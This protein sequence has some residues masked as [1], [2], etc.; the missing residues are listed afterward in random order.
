MPLVHQNEG[1]DKWRC[2]AT[3]S[4]VRQGRALFNNIIDRILGEALHEHPGVQPGENVHVSDLTYADVIVILCSSY[5]EL[6]GL[7]EA[8]DR[9]AAAFGTRVNA[10]KTNVMSA[11]TPCEQRQALLPDGESPDYKY[12]SPVQVRT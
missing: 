12:K 9:H 4:G 7:L 1:Q 8:V 5:R 6:Q 3:F 11:F 10:S 2:F